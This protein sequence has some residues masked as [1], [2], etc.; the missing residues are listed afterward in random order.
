[1]IKPPKYCE[2]AIPTNMGWQD[3]N[4]G[5]IIC[6]IRNLLN[7]LRQAAANEQKNQQEAVNSIIE[8]LKEEAD[9]EKPAT[10]E[11]ESL[12]PRCKDEAE[13]GDKKNWV[14]DFARNYGSPDV[15]TR[16]KKNRKSGD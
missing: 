9:I 1:M 3:P 5:K 13:E 16:R 15:K 7:L 10:I 6:R 12:V 11:D 2:N 14:S 4:T 8:K